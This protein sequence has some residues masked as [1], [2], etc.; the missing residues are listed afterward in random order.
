MAVR[1]IT[2]P[3]P[4]VSLRTADLATAMKAGSTGP[5]GPLGP[6]GAGGSSHWGR[7]WDASSP[8]SVT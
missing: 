1:E 8:H 2:F 5:P 3:S 7:P 4:L 6:Q